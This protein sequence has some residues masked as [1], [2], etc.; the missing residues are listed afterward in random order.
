LDSPEVLKRPEV[1]ALV[2]AAVAQAKVPFQ[3]RGRGK[4]VI[5]SISA[6]Q[7]PRKRPQGSS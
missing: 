1:K 5:R 4:L 3:A 7:L 2:A 6:K